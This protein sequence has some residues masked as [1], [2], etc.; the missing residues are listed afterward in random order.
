MYTYITHVSDSSW[1]GFGSFFYLYE[2][3]TIFRYNITNSPGQQLNDHRT[4]GIR[5]HPQGLR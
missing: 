1:F 3:M 4:P 5:R 2:K